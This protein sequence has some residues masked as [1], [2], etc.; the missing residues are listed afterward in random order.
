MRSATW[1]FRAIAFSKSLKV[2]NAMKKAKRK[3]S[4]RSASAVDRYIGARMRERRRE[5]EMSQADLGKELGVTFQ[6]IQK[7][8]KGINR[9]SAARSSAGI[10]RRW[11]KPAELPL[12][13]LSEDNSCAVLKVR[14]DDLSTDRQ[15]G[16]GTINRHRRGGKAGRRSNFRPDQLIEI[17]ILLPVDLNTSHPGVGIGGQS[18]T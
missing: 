5:L 17:W 7:Y 10:T 12:H 13:E 11:H 18:T 15:T 8:E 4:L 14:P 2:N 1:R 3:I 6:Q 9:V 16:L